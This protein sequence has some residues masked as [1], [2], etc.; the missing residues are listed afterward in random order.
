[1]TDQ[2][3]QST[4]TDGV[5]EAYFAGE[6]RRFAL[7]LFGELRALQDKHDIGP[8][9]FEMIF[10][11][12]AWRAE[13]VAD[14]IRLALIGAGMDDQEAAKLVEAYVTEGRLL[15]YVPLAHDIILAT[16]G[17]ADPE[18]T[19]KKPDAAGEKKRAAAKSK[20]A[21]S[22]NSPILK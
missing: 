14:T 11:G 1:M 22:G 13:H 20:S 2:G 5:H 12:G 4:R 16:L 8:A 21:P 18:E 7:P 15:K 10:R 6:R 17:P 9:G 19:E 3:T